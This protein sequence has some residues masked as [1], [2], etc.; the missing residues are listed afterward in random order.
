M[1]CFC[2]GV[3]VW[4]YGCFLCRCEIICEMLRAQELLAQVGLVQ[5]E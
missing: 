4:L 2:G 5:S 3:V 1:C